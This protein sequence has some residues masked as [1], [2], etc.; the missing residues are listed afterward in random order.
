MNKITPLISS[1]EAGPIGVLHLPRLW[2]K[3]S[4]DARGLLADGYP[5]VG[6]GFDQMVLD[7]LGL[8]KE[9]VVGFITTQRPTYSEFEDWIKVQPG[10]KLD[11][12]SIT[13]LNDSLTGY[14]HDDET[15]SGILSEAGVPSHCPFRDA[16]N[17][18][19]L[20]DW[21]GFHS[22]FLK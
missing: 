5:A 22:A 18:N 7:G 10:A 2:L 14:V 20:E 11:K 17:L 1:S 9:A 12:T 8:K 16:I 15:R 13:K 3:V 4:L 19:N 6:T 21:K